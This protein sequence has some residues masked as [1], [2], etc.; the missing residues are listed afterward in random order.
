MQISSLKSKIYT[1]IGLLST[2]KRMVLPLSQNGFLKWIP[3]ELF[4]KIAYWGEMDTK[5][6]LKHPKTFSEKIQWLKLNDRKNRYISM[7]D[8][9]LVKDIVADVIGKEY[10]IPTLCSW[11]SVK[12]IDFDSLPGSFVL[13]C[14]HDSGGVVICRDKSMFD[15]KAAI[16]KL[17]SH[18]RKNSYLSSREW[19]YKGIKKRIIAEELLQDPENVD[20]ID[21]KFYCF[22]GEPKYCQVIKD[23]STAETIDFYDLDWNLMPFTGLGL[24]NGPDRG[25]YT[26][27]PEN[28]NRMIEIAKILAQGTYFV[29]IDMYNISGKIYFGEFTLYPRSG[30]GKFF[31]EEWNLHLGNMIDLGEKIE[32]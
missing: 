2:P 28:Y 8:K 30:F 7:V 10:I 15:T 5:L 14:N 31:P 22:G 1:F 3:D 17:E 19:P 6:N 27:K 25:S 16:T 24:G 26:S 18:F 13:K 29:R 4:L 11:K 20:L 12:E 32:K 9:Y 23:R 21:Y